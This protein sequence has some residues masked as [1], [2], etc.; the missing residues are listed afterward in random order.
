[1]ERLSGRRTRGESERWVGISN[2]DKSRG[3]R[4]RRP[5]SFSERASV[6]ECGGWNMDREQSEQV[7]EGMVDRLETG[8][9]RREH[10]RRQ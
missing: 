7:V 4:R 10:L 3:K 2:G 9:F 8:F 6:V 5:G 1:M